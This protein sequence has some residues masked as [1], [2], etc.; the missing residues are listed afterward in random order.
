MYFQPGSKILKAARKS[1][2]HL[3]KRILLYGNVVPYFLLFSLKTWLL[4][5]CRRILCGYVSHILYLPFLALTLSY[6]FGFSKKSDSFC[7]NHII[8]NV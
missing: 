2:S 4:H 5:F 7:V 3:G 1:L 6:I 8:G